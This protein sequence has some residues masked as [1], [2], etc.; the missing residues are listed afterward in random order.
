MYAIIATAGRQ[1][2]V[3]KDDIID[4]DL[5]DGKEGEKVTFSE[6]LAEG[7]GKDIKLGNPTIKGAKV[8]GEIIKHFRGVKLIAFKMKRRKG[9]RKTKGHRSELTKV[10]ITSIES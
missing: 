8:T 4:V 1:Y 2:R 5:M 3:K 9:Y 7:E 10:K 6:V